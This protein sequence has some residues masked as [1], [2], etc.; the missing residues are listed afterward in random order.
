MCFQIAGQY[1]KESTISFICSL[2][3][4]NTH[5]PLYSA[6]LS[7]QLGYGGFTLEVKVASRL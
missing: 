6:G 4:L 2:R 5:L 7:N 1:R 3:S